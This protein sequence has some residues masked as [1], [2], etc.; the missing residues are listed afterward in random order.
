MNPLITPAEL[1]AR[2][3]DP[4]TIVLDA[5]LAP[6]GS[7]AD[8]YANFLAQHIPGALFFDIEELSD[9]AT[10]LPHMLP[11]PADFAHA[12]SALGVSDT[13]N[14]VV[15]EQTGVF[16]APRAWWTLRTFGAPNVQI[17]DGGLQAWLTANLPTQSG[18]VER[19]R[20]TFHPTFN[21]NAVVDFPQ[22]QNLLQQNAQILDARSAARFHGTAP[23][24]R[25]NLPSGHMPGALNLPFTHLVADGRLKPADELRALFTAAGIDLD[26]PVTTT[27]GSGVTAAVLLFGLQI[28]GATDLTLYDGSWAEYAQHPEATILTD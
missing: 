16:S 24:P 21:P 26:R 6:P 22:L 15:Y 8:P 20:A 4:N 25:P 28:A 3:D 7:T 12:M 14:I 2:L 5:T 18:P 13:A 19:M 17:L 10:N 1:L 11:T 27:C 9:Y 23:E